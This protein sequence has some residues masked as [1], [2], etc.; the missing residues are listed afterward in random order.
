MNRSELI[1]NIAEKSELTKKQSEAALAALLSSVTEELSK[2]GSVVLP[3]FGSFSVKSRA[4]RTGRN[5]K[6]GEEIQIPAA[7][8]PSFKAGKTLKDSVAK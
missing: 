4:A 6:T 7:V 1:S 8:L 5:P 2:G 3:G